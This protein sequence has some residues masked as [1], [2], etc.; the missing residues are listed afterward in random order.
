M[1][2]AEHILNQSAATD[3]LAANAPAIPVERLAV[4]GPRSCVYQIERLIL[5]IERPEVREIVGTVFQNLL[6]LIE[7]L[8]LIE[9]H[10]RQVDAADETYALFQLIHDEARTLVQYIRTDALS[11]S[12]MSAELLDTLD[13]ITFALSHDLQRVFEPNAL[14]A[15]T[16]NPTHIVIGKLYRAHDVLTNCLQ[17]STIT[18]AMIFDPDLIG[19]RL[20]NNSDMRY[21]QSLQLCE[22]IASLLQLVE[23]CETINT[24]EAG[25]RLSAGIDSFRQESL[26][27]LMYSDWPQFESFSERMALPAK[28][29][30]R[31][32]TLHQFRCYLETLLGQVRMRA[33]LANVFPVQFGEIDE[34]S[35]AHAFVDE[36]EISSPLA[37]AG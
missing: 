17:H 23:D 20:F 36:T 9:S 18:L 7:C 1:T 33:V 32:S 12:A 27:Y 24:D 3:S 35:I 25:S 21:R 2:L 16:D 31:E 22:D 37:L 10:L 6:G 28:S 13:G 30:E 19:A 29:Q 26:E 15:L 14:A 11:S 5:G 4:A 34:T 8:D